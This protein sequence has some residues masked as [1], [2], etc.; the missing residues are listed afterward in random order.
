M[1]TLLLISLMTTALLS[2]A[3][4]VDADDS[5][6][7]VEL[8]RSDV[9]TQKVAIVTEV[10]DFTDEQSEKFWPIY[11]EYEK[12]LAGVGDERLAVIKDYAKVYDRITDE[13]A[14]EL[15]DRTFKFRQAELKTMKKYY[16]QVEKAL[17]GATAAKW[18]QVE[19]QLNMLIDLQIASNLPLLE[20]APVVAKPAEQG[21]GW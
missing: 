11:R 12:D 2:G 7:Y 21:G 10:M 18:I 15:V 16:D 8:L 14:K 4:A 1:R 6:K 20:G 5:D 19:N 17:G 9:K 3:V 13:Q